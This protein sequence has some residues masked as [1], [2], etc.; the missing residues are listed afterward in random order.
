MK[1]RVQQL[2]SLDP[3]MVIFQLSSAAAIEFLLECGRNYW[4]PKSLY[5]RPDG[6]LPAA[7]DRKYWTW[8]PTLLDR[9]TLLPFS[10]FNDTSFPSTNTTTSMTFARLNWTRVFNSTMDFSGISTTVSIGF[11][12]LQRAIRALGTYNDTTALANYIQA[13]S[14]PSMFGMVTFGPLGELVGIDRY[15]SQID[16][17]YY[18][19]I[20]FPCSPLHSLIVVFCTISLRS[21]PILLARFRD[22]TW[23]FPIPGGCPPPS[24][25]PAAVCD[26]RTLLWVL[27]SSLTIGT[28]RPPSA[29]GAPSAPATPVI[30]STPTIVNGNVSIFQSTVV[31]NEGSGSDSGRAVEPGL[32][33]ATGCVNINGGVL[34]IPFTVSENTT[35][36]DTASR[37]VVVSQAQCLTGT[38]DNVTA[39]RSG[40]GSSCLTVTARSEYSP[41]SLSVVFT[42]ADNCPSL[43]VPDAPLAVWMIAVIVVGSVVVVVLIIVGIICTP[44]VR[45]KVAPG[46]EFRRRVNGFGPGSS[47][48]K[49]L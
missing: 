42:V 5:M 30:I 28:P 13:V 20:V 21:P 12:I 10:S 35:T 14:F 11:S 2:I 22:G 17:N 39:I 48:Q 46:W 27:N 3:D 26:R 6:F 40:N 41:T 16:Q 9:A 1:N 23:T 8:V 29:P 15:I 37:T 34:Q 18:T 4:V 43:A 47:A 31:I 19:R 36:G 33:N 32:I 45:R 24:P 44:C 38:F 25:S 49:S 7:I